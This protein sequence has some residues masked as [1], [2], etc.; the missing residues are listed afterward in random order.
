MFVL[1]YIC[2]AVLYCYAPYRQAI[3]KV[4]L[5]FK[6]MFKKFIVA[7][8]AVLFTLGASAQASTRGGDA[9]Q[10]GVP[11][12]WK[13][14]VIEFSVGAGTGHG[15][16]SPLEIGGTLGYRFLPRM[17]AFA[18]GGCLYGMYDK[19]HG[20]VYTKSATLAGGLGY[21]LFKAGNVDVDLRASAGGSVGNADWK[22]TVYDGGVAFRIGGTGR[23]KLNVGLGYR[24]ITS[25]TAGIGAYNG[26]YGTIGVGF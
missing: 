13:N 9:A 20:R 3:Y 11:S 26:L 5:N 12:F 19:D 15:G 23:L 7:A 6:L 4:K 21:T 17:Y 10:G 22:H 16:M 1:Y 14:V 18:H 25:H 8:A 24:H 2:N